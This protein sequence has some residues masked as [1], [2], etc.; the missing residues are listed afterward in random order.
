MAM[1]SVKNS[2]GTHITQ[3]T[4]AQ[5]EPPFFNAPPGMGHKQQRCWG[6]GGGQRRGRGCY[7]VDVG[8]AG[9][10]KKFRWVLALL[11]AVAS[12]MNGHITI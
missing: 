6:G 3:E 9:V 7:R 12:L 5:R 10:A 8:A 4:C 11:D 2:S 1:T